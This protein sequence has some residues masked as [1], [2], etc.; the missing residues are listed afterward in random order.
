MTTNIKINAGDRHFVASHK[1]ITVGSARLQR[2]FSDD[3]IYASRVLHA[4][5][6]SSVLEIC[7]D[8]KVYQIIHIFRWNHYSFVAFC[9]YDKSHQSKVQ[10]PN[11]D[12]SG[13]LGHQERL[14]LKP[15]R[16]PPSSTVNTLWGSSQTYPVF[17]SPIQHHETALAAMS[18]AQNPSGASGLW[19]YANGLKSLLTWDIRSNRWDTSERC[20][21]RDRLQ[22]P[23]IL[24]KV[25][26]L[27]SPRYP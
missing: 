5:L 19:K 25:Q 12:L 24:E 27:G 1:F 14:V 22:K 9:R 13:L 11:G 8:I 2:A 4:T 3:E 20:D 26:D 16:C 15:F 7:A 17:T 23:Q 21:F 18:W 6:S 10:S